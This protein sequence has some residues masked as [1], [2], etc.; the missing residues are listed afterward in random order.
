MLNKF[1]PVLYGVVVFAIYALLTF[2]LRLITGRMPENPEFLGIYTSNDLLLGLVVS[3]V[4]TLS[5]QR[6]KKFK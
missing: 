5:H 4:L 6:K 1:K 3:V 2:I